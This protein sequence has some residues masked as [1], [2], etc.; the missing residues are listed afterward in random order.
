MTFFSH[1][2][3]LFSLFPHI[4]SYITLFLTHNVYLIKTISPL[5]RF[6]LL[7][8]SHDSNNI[9]S[10]NIGGSRRTDAWAAPTS[11]FGEGPSPPQ[12]PKSPPMATVMIGDRLMF[13][14]NDTNAHRNY[15]P[16]IK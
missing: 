14:Q 7:E 10:P 11:N 12:P 16:L 13:N 4:I 2:P 15:M 9:T 6:S 5:H 1:Q 3:F 8:L